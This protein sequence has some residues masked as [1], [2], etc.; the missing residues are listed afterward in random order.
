M[1]QR[2]LI[3][4]IEFMVDGILTLIMIND[5]EKISYQ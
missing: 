5:N 4:K 1:N 2:F 3:L